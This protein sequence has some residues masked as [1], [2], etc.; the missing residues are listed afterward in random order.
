MLCKKK[1][2]SFEY[3]FHF[4]IFGVLFCGVTGVMSGANLSGEL[5]NPA[6]SIP[7]GTLSACAFTLASFLVLYLLTVLT[8]NAEF[9]LHDCIY[10]QVFHSF[11]KL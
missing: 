7:C 2:E 1:C 9:L 3:V 10:L 8:C 5:V 6:F 4:Q 11:N